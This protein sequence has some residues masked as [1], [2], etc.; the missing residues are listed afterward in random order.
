[1]PGTQQFVGFP[2]S[3]MPVPVSRPQRVKQPKSTLMLLRTFCMWLAC[4]AFLTEAMPSDYKANPA[5]MQTSTAP[6]ARGHDGCG[7]DF[8]ENQ[9]TVSDLDSG[10]SSAHH[11]GLPSCRVCCNT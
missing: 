2:L 8:K 7:D 3:E 11:V 4:E 1:M 5:I 10:M 9:T 6:D